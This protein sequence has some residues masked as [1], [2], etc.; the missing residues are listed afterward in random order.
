MPIGRRELLQAT[1]ALAAWC[2]G[3]GKGASAGDA[4]PKDAGSTHYGVDGVPTANAAPAIA[5]PHLHAPASYHQDIAPPQHLDVA[6]REALLRPPP[7]V[8]GPPR[9]REFELWA[10]EQPIEIADGVV[11]PAW[12]YNGSIPGPVL[13]ATEG[14][15]LVVR[16]RNL[17]TAPHNV[18]FHGR[19]AVEQDGWEPVPVG[20][21]ATYRFAAEPRG[22]HPYHCHSMPVSDHLARGLYGTLIVDP[23]GG[24]PPAHELVLALCGFDTNGDGRDE[25]FGWNGIAGLYARHPIKVP[26][27]E[28]VRIHLVNLAFH[29]PAITFH[30]HA[31]TFDV[32]R[33]GTRAE[34]DDHTDVV[35]LGPAERAILEFRLPRRGRYMFHPHQSRVAEAGAMGWIA[36][37]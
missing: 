36:A 9:E 20:G 19:H 30:L 18:H 35:T 11:F 23:P 33:S 3:P 37:V 10:S 14:D 26:V 5:T 25:L 15:T 32:F 24:R 8:I 31:E 34:P 4:G 22:V 1:G 29:E 28:L 7:F 27:G 6:A 21:E 2:F 13:R 17:G 16:F 12:T